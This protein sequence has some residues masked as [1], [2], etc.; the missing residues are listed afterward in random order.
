MS[1]IVWVF[2]THSATSIAVKV[3][4]KES[5]SAGIVMAGAS[6]SEFR[7]S[8]AL[9]QQ[10]WQKLCRLRYLGVALGAHAAEWPVV[11]DFSRFA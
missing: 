6:S 1:L 8:Q 5:N 4:S 3:V 7:I 10:R 11:H 9:R 2:V